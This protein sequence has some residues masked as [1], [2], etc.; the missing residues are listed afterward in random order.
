MDD[1]FFYYHCSL[2]SFGHLCSVYQEF[3]P[4]ADHVAQNNAEVVI[5]SDLQT[6][7]RDSGRVREGSTC[8]Q[9]SALRY[10]LHIKT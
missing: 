9:I 8:E 3:L 6:C 1:F 10:M 7:N 2:M 5:E 4:P